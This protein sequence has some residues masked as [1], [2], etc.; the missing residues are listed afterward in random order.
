MSPKYKKITHED[1]L[2][3]INKVFTTEEGKLLLDIWTDQ[4]MFRKIANEGDDLLTIG[5]HQGEAGFVLSIV[6]LIEQ[7]KEK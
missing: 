4:F 1:Y 6:R 2:S 5:I 3:L 7:Y